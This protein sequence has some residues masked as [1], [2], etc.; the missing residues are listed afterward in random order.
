MSVLLG[1]SLKLKDA[2]G[3]QELRVP[4][5]GVSLMGLRSLISVSPP[6]APSP[7]VARCPNLPPIPNPGFSSTGPLRADVGLTK[8]FANARGSRLKDTV[9][10]VLQG[11]RHDTR[12]GNWKHNSRGDQM[13]QK[14]PPGNSNL[15]SRLAAA[16]TARTTAG[17][18][19]ESETDRNRPSIPEMQSDDD[20]NAR[21]Q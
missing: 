4:V 3:P 15:S 10:V 16:N 7:S 6:R 21:V 13:S 18:L 11:G 14:G 12:P 17:R 2:L 1:F 5:P 9:D 19:H 8:A 20:L